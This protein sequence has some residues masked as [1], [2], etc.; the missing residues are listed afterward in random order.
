M[1][2]LSPT[3]RRRVLALGAGLWASG[4]AARLDAAPLRPAV[5]RAAI[6]RSLNSSRSTWIPMAITSTGKEIAIAVDAV[7]DGMQRQDAT[8]WFMAIAPELAVKIERGEN[9]GRD[10]VYYNVVR[11]LVPAGMW[12]GEPV[13]LNLPKDDLMAECCKGCVALLQ[14]KSVGPI[15]GCATWGTLGA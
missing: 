2:I 15:I 14:A 1:Y 7:P 13:T 10:M 9:A 6:E 4:L 11:R 8:V 12:H 3:S 5:V